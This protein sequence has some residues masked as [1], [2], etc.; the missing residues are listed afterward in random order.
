MSS[1][2]YDFQVLRYD[3]LLP[4]IASTRANQQALE[5]ADHFYTPPTGMHVTLTRLFRHSTSICQII[6]VR[7]WI[8]VSCIGNVLIF[9]QLLYSVKLPDFNSYN[10][11]I[12]RF[13]LNFYFLDI[14][15]LC[16]FYASCK[17]ITVGYSIWTFAV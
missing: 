8:C 13:L 14:S 3:Y 9:V 4:K 10:N 16:R 5:K 17:N 2:R 1:S 11:A 15:I 7:N 6:S 12:C